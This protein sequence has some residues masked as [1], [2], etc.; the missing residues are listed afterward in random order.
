MD[1]VVSSPSPTALPVLRQPS[2]FAHACESMQTLASFSSTAMD[3]YFHLDRVFWCQRASVHDAGSSRS[4]H[5]WP[6]RIGFSNCLNFFF[7]KL[8]P[9]L[10]MQAVTQI[11]RINFACHLCNHLD[12]AEHFARQPVAA[13]CRDQ[14]GHY[15]QKSQ[16]SSKGTRY[17]RCS[18]S[19]SMIITHQDDKTCRES[20]CSGHACQL[21]FADHPQDGR[22]QRL[23]ANQRPG[24]ITFLPRRAGDQL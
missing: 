16:I 13:Q 15:A 18:P 20:S 9:A 6:G 3:F 19:S 5:N 12:R 8:V 1:W 21:H 7:A 23:R 11:G 24:S 10:Q 17:G 4:P 2:V 22:A 14:Q